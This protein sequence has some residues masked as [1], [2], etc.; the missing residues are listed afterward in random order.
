MIGLIILELIIQVNT[1]PPPYDYT[2]WVL[3]ALYAAGSTLLIW[4]LSRNISNADEKIKELNSSLEEQ[5]KEFLVALKDVSK[6]VET[7]KDNT[8]RGA[9]DT[10]EKISAMALKISN[11]IKDLAVKIAS[12]IHLNDNSVK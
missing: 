4:S 1:L 6:D 11:D 12:G 7:L 10:N 9:A 8:V 2:G 3:S 5:R